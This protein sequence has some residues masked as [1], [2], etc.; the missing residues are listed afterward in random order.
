MGSHRASVRYAKSLIELSQEKKLLEKVIEDMKLFS[1]T[2]EENREFSVILKNPIIPADKKKAIIKALFEKKVQ[3]ITL[4]AFALIV[5]KGRENILDEIA[6]EFIN[7]YNEL[8]GIVRA[9]VTTAYTLDDSQRKEIIK[10]VEELTGKKADL[11][12]LVDEALI[13]GFLL[14]IGDK[15]VD[16]S[17][18]NKLAKIQRAL[19]A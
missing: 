1:K 16:E 9:T 13:G 7:G 11:K 10:V 18:K 14:K 4:D 3:P 12:E 19:V 17:V 5:S 8:K 15:Q 2:I 6:L